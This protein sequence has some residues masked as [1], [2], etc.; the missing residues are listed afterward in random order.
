MGLYF[1]PF[2]M[3]FSGEMKLDRHLLYSDQFML[4]LGVVQGIYFTFVVFS[5]INIIAVL[6]AIL[7]LSSMH[8]TIIDILEVYFYHIYV[9]L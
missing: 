7:I 8:H 4:F 9:L 2:K 3:A 6:V 5:H 1:I